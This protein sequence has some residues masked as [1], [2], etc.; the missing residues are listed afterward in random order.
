MEISVHRYVDDVGVGGHVVGGEVMVGEVTELQVG[1]G[2]LEQRHG[3]PHGHG[4]DDLGA[5]GT[6][7][8]HL[9]GGEYAQQ[10]GRRGFGRCRCPPRPA[11]TGRRDRYGRA[12]RAATSSAVSTVTSTPATGIAP[13]RL[14]TAWNTARLAFQPPKPRTPRQGTRWRKGRNLARPADVELHPLQGYAQGVRR[15]PREHGAGARADVG[16]ADAHEE[17]AV[18]P[19]LRC[20]GRRTRDRGVR[21]AA[22]L[23]PTSHRPSRRAAGAESRWPQ[24]K[25]AAPSRRHATRLRLL[26]SPRSRG[27]PELVGDAKFGG[28]DPGP[29]RQF[30]DR[31]R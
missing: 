16:G 20:R 8:D 23:E 12:A 28:I 19:R 13:S 6:R 11:R 17:G 2:R 14:S 25:R 21:P 5:G 31:A 24:L 1:V 18:R 15:D 9:S 3:Q 10:C 29:I 30:V 27:H 7:V 22:A 26:T 4:S